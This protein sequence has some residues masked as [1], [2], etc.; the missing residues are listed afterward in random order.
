MAQHYIAVPLDH[1]VIHLSLLHA[2]TYTNQVYN[3]LIATGY[4][5]LVQQAV[6]GFPSTP[7]T[8]NKKGPIPSKAE[9]KAENPNRTSSSPKPP[10]PKPHR[11]NRRVFY[12]EEAAR[13]RNAALRKPSKP[14]PTSTPTKSSSSTGTNPT[15]TP[16]KRTSPEHP[17]SP[18]SLDTIVEMHA[19]TN[20]EA[21]HVPQD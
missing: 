11:A 3:R 10:S 9:V 17:I 2:L 21:H 7:E 20:K 15:S 18:K 5:N 6:L 12:L 16:T 4:A 13:A 8:S 14:N 19:Q 1:T